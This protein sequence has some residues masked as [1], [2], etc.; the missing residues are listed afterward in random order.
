MGCFSPVVGG[1]PSDLGYEGGGGGDR[2]VTEGLFVPAN[3]P[4]VGLSRARYV[5]ASF[6]YRLAT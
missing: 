2:I 6:V 5:V 3:G 4:F 1:G